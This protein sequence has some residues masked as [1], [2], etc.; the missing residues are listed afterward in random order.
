[1][2]DPLDRNHPIMTEE[3]LAPYDMVAGF[4]IIVVL[5]FFVAYLGW[6]IARWVL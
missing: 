5:G 3:D 6:Q 1:M 2:S 4:I